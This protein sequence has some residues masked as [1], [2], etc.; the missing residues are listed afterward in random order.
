MNCPQ[1]ANLVPAFHGRPPIVFHRLEIVPAEYTRCDYLPIKMPNNGMIKVPDN[2]R[3]VGRFVDCIAVIENLAADTYWYLTAKYGY[4]GADGGN[5]PGWHCDGYLTDDITYIWS[6]RS[7]TEFCLQ[8]FNLTPDHHISL[9]EMEQQARHENIR[10]FGDGNIVRL[11]QYNVHR[12]AKCAPG[13]RC[14]LKLS[15]SK[16]QYNLT[17]NAH[18]Y[19]FDYKWDMHERALERNHPQRDYES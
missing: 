11:D 18:N 1:Y 14:F 16:E 2:L 10:T 19:L 8:E 7:A 15:I 9:I 6:D 12:V 5:R 13:L 17:G 3:W 4:V